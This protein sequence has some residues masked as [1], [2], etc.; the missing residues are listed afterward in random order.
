MDTIVYQPNP[1]RVAMRKVFGGV[2]MAFG[3][4]LGCTFLGASPLILSLMLNQSDGAASGTWLFGLMF[5]CGGLL[6]LIVFI[7]VGLLIFRGSG[8]EQLELS[9]HALSHTQ[10]KT[11]TSLLLNEITHLRGQWR[12]GTTASSH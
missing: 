5:P 7:V 11:T 1:G 2:F 4:I 6:F 3:V 9:S 10:G 8:P 12:M